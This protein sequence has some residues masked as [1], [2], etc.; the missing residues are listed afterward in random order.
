ME[1]RP[2]HWVNETTIQQKKRLIMNKDM[3]RSKAFITLTGPAKQILMELYIRLTVDCHKSGRNK[4]DVQYYAKNNGNLILRYSEMQKMFGYSPST[5]SRAIDNLVQN[6]FVEI[7]RLGHGVQRQEHKFALIK[8]W[9]QFGTADFWVGQGKANR[10]INNGFK[11]KPTI[12]SE[13]V[14]LSNVTKEG[15]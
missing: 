5:I 2:T 15:E 8:N 7:A 11:K 3:I 13:V 14:Q 4:K 10:P 9:Q 1:A 6:G 12:E